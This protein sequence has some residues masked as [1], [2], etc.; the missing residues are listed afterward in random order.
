MARAVAG[1]RPEA[2]VIMCT[3]LRFAVRSA[4]VGKQLGLRMIDS[5]AATVRACLD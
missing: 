1:Q 4:T 5:V 2:I 3:N